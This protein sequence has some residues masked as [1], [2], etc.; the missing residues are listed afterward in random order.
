MRNR[1]CTETS[2]ALVGSSAKGARKLDLI[3]EFLNP[4]I[5]FLTS[6]KFREHERLANALT[7]REARIER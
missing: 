6:G 4:A 1:A 2:S 5:E 3:E 7:D